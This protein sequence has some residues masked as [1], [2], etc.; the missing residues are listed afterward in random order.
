MRKL[1]AALVPLAVL[2]GCGANDTCSTAPAAL[3][4]VAQGCT[5]K[6]GATVSLGVQL[7]CQNCNGQSSPE[8]SG[9]VVQGEIQLNSIF[10]E[11]QGDTSCPIECGSKKITCSVPTPNVSGAVPVTFIT[12]G[13]G[14]QTVTVTLSPNGATSCTL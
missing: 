6:S 8:C 3:T 12:A 13:G 5:L 9:E 14:T 7:D 1:L 11:C 2:A 10:H 4:T